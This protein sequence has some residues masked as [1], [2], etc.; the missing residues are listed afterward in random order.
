MR[1]PSDLEQW[2]VRYPERYNPRGK[3]P[4]NVW[5]IPIP[6]Q[7]SWANTKV[8]H[9]C[10]LPPDLVERMLLI[11]TDKGDVVLDPFAGSGVVIAEAARIGRRSLGFELVGDHIDAFHDAVLP[12]ITERRGRDLLQE[13]QH[14]S[15]DLRDT[16]FA[17]GRRNIRSPSIA[18]PAKSTPVF[19]GPAHFALARA[20]TKAAEDR[21]IFVLAQCDIPRQED[22]MTALARA[23]RRRPNSKFGVDPQI[24]VVAQPEQ[25][26]LHRGRTLWAYVGGVVHSAAGPCRA[27]DVGEWMA[28]PSR[29]DLPLIVSNVHVDES[30]RALRLTEEEIGP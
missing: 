8:Q 5:P 15:E 12:E 19:P 30:P 9:A 7:G 21:A 26:R 13:L 17:G 28:E 27:A 25:R 23:S 11:S 24:R 10:P 20:L 14:R 1:Q 29:H 6:V 3:A 16:I 18:R 2:W 22:L 4:T